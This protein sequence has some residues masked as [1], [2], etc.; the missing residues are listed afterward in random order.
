MTL[1]AITCPCCNVAIPLEA[2]F[3]HQG[4]RD[5]F[6]SLAS[7]H[8]SHRLSMTALRYVGLFAPARQAMRWD[9]IADLMGEIKEIVSTGRVNWK[10]QDHAAP[11]EYWINAMEHMLADTS[12]RRPL[13]S[14]NYLK[15]IVAGMGEKVASTAETRNEN[16]ARGATQ[17]GTHASHQDFK[18][19]KQTG[20]ADPEMAKAALARVKKSLNHE[21]W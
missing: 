8:P 3:A 15:A 12:L 4:A 16:S 17:T 9:R 11:L 7:L 5:A 20:R 2:V 19:A 21:R 13:T 1:P 10:H 14:H 6:I 18:P